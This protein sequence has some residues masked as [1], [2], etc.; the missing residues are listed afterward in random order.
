MA[1]QLLEAD[2]D[3]IV[4]NR[5]KSKTDALKEKGA[6][7]AEN[8]AEAIDKA[9]LF[10]TM[11]ADYPAICDVLF[12]NPFL[13]FEGK[14]LIQMGTIS[15]EQSLQIKERFE[16]AGGEYME[17]P[18][19]GSIPQAKSRTLFVL[20]GATKAQFKKMES[21]LKTFG[22]QVIYLGEVGQ[23]AAAKLALNQLIASLT[24][25]FSMSLSYL[26]EKRISVE[27]FMDILRQSALYA[28]TFDKKLERLMKRDF[29][30]PNFPVKHLF[31]DVQLILDEFSKAGIDTSPLEGVQ[32]ILA[33]AVEKG[34]S[35]LDYSALYNV[36]H[37]ERD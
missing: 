35:E 17:A 20:C 23:A 36:I 24:A 33:E 22:D 32:E 27:K 18:V 34:L 21:L 6:L 1:Q 19:L 37:P 12:F 5:T 8:A 25:A 26:R 4:F 9:D 29:E 16:S 28:P 31:K 10:I 30:Q 7:V 14:T 15:P 11:L 13:Q 2:Y 3:L